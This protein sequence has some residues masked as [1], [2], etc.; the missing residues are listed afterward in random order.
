MQKKLPPICADNISAV[1]SRHIQ[2]TACSG[3]RRRYIPRCRHKN[4]KCAFSL[5]RTFF[6]SPKNIISISILD[7][8]NAIAADEL[9]VKALNVVRIAAENAGRLVL[10]EN[11]LVVF[12]K[13]LNRITIAYSEVLSELNRDNESSELINFS[14]YACGFHMYSRSFHSVLIIYH[15]MLGKSRLKSNK[16]EHFGILFIFHIFIVQKCVFDVLFW[17]NTPIYAVFLFPIQRR[18]SMLKKIFCV[19]SAISFAFALAMGKMDA[20]A[21]A[22]I[23]GA[24]KAVSLSISLLG[25]TALWCGIMEVYSKC[26]ACRLLAK[27]ISPLMKLLF[28]EACKSGIGTEEIAANISANLL[29]LGNAATPLG[30][31][32]MEKLS[33][34]NG[35]SDEASDDM[36][37][38]AVLNTSSV[39]L[40]PTTLIALRRAAGSV[41]PFDIIP[42]VWICSVCCCIVSMLFARGL[43]HLF[44]KKKPRAEKIWNT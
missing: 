14:Y 7:F 31:K 21:S 32:A 13:N 35:G 38:F 10:L 39:S 20:L 2:L 27:L 15:I 30:I 12:D 4:K 36:V 33:E 40:M 23:D 29:G 1:A 18:L 44:P 37:T 28:P 3:D 34:P 43:R 5:K 41:S 17:S 11:D 42:A 24:S 22:I 9:A 25:L 19:I 8:L 6:V 26:G 16:C